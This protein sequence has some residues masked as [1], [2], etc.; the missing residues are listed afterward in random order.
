MA[1][2]GGSFQTY[3]LLNRSSTRIMPVE[4]SPIPSEHEKDPKGVLKPSTL[5][6]MDEFRNR[7]HEIP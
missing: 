3:A 1:K 2:K 4:M 6:K 7:I 5:R